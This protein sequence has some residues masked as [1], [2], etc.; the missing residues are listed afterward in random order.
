MLG[1][2]SS[3]A[4]YILMLPGEHVSTN[5]RWTQIS[6]CVYFYNLANYCLSKLI[7]LD[8]SLRVS[9]E[10]LRLNQ[11]Y[12]SY[13][14]LQSDKAK[15]NFKISNSINFLLTPY[16]F[17]KPDRCSFFF[18]YLGGRGRGGE[19]GIRWDM[20]HDADVCK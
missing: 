7:L 10:N 4:K 12:Q 5:N 19:Y 14:Q 2:K 16:S 15:F 9:G 17:R 6:Q 13:A 20:V 8:T 3:I 1:R 18:F 11:N